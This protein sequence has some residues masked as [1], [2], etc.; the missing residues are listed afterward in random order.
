MEK[1]TTMNDAN[2]LY[3]FT[4]LTPGTYSVQFVQPAGFTSVIPLDGG[5]DHTKDSGAK[6]SIMLTTAQVTLASGDNNTTLDA[7][8]YNPASLGDFVW[9]DKNANGVRSEERR[10]GKEWTSQLKGSG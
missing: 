8:F 4:G 6:S 7:G 3:G 5:S 10:V 2:G 1:D 9:N